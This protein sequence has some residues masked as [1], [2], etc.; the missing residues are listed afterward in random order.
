[1]PDREIPFY[2]GFLIFSLLLLSFISIMCDVCNC[3]RDCV[4]QK[5]T[6]ESGERVLGIDSC[7]V[8]STK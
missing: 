3:S 1:M 2:L 8:F 6:F 7:F 5:T 4:G